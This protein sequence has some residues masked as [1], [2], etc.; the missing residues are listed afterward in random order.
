MPPHPG[1]K[2]SAHPARKPWTNGLRSRTQNLLAEKSR[3]K[4]AC[5]GSGGPRIPG[6]QKTLML[7]CRRKGSRWVRFDGSR[8]RQSHGWP[9]L[10]RLPE[11]HLTGTGNWLK[12][13]KEFTHPSLTSHFLS[14]L[15]LADAKSL[16]SSVAYLMIIFLSHQAGSTLCEGRSLGHL[17]H[18]AISAG[19]TPP[20]P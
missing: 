3:T 20:V 12:E 15:L 8:G 6:G 10:G 2:H 16:C 11:L 5:K 19:S 14:G 1:T 4:G 9:Q 7:Q 18:Q 17:V 13:P